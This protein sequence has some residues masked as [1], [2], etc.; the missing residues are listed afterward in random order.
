MNWLDRFYGRILRVVLRM[1]WVTLLLTILIF[2]GS[3]YAATF[4]TFSF[5]PTIDQHQFT[6][7][8]KLP[9]GTPLA[10]VAG[11]GDAHRGDPAPASLPSPTS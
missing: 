3:V 4:L 2:A 11:R 6:M 7:Q 8:V 1:K 9:A 10:A 5:V